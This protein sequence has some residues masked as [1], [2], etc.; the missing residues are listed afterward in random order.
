MHNNDLY[1]I[2]LYFEFAILIFFDL[3]PIDSIFKRLS[4]HT[5]K[6]M[7]TMPFVHKICN[8]TE[9]SLQFLNYLSF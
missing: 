1:D 9:K 2:T 4:E 7:T 8:K 6:F 3:F 5:L